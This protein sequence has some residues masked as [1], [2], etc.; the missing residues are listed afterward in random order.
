MSLSPLLYHWFVRPRWFTRK[1]I[2][3]PISTRFSFDHK[4][5][6]DF[7]SGTGANCR[8]CDPALYIGIEPDIKRIKLAKRLYPNHR[9]VAFDE[10]RIPIPDGSIDYILIVAVLHHIS[11][12]QVNQYLQ[13]FARVLK[14]NGKLVV[15]EPYLCSEKEFNNRF[16]NWYDDGNFI[17][18]EEGYLDLFRNAAFEF[19]VIKKFTKCFVYNEFFF[20]AAPKSKMTQPSQYL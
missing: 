20:V 7:G 2:H 3:N 14:S 16:M 12:D 13:E 15:I 5:V 9:F 11:D 18:S 1:Y 6:L 19:T 8:I 10:Q 4:T 17:R